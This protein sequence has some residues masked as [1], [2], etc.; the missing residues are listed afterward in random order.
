MKV[1]LALAKQTLHVFHIIQYWSKNWLQKQSFNIKISSSDRNGYDHS[2][3]TD[4][5][6]CYL[7]SSE[8][9]FGNDIIMVQ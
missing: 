6:K 1:Y 4:L 8:L 5:P 3:G 2:N 9:N 7:P